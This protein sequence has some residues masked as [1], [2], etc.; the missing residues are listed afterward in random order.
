MYTYVYIDSFPDH[1]P[2]RSL[3]D[4]EYLYSDTLL[5]IHLICNSLHLLIPSI[6]SIP[7]TQLF[8]NHKVVLYV[9]MSVL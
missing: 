6:Q 4:I 3:Q 7:P 5:F 1:F 2:F 9:R 8:G